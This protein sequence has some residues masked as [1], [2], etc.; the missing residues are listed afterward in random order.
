MVLKE[1]VS[2][3]G[4]GVLFGRTRETTKSFIELAGDPTEIRK[5]QMPNEALGAAPNK[6]DCTNMH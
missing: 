4:G 3:N 5:K 1:A 6:T 2:C